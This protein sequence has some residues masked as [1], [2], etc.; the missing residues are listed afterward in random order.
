MRDMVD[1]WD[2]SFVGATMDLECDSE[3]F[4]A[5]CPECDTLVECV[6]EKDSSTGVIQAYWNTNEYHKSLCY[7]EFC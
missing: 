6:E 5:M 2:R 3:A 4:N 7:G 1:A